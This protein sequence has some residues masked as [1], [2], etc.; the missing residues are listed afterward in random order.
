LTYPELKK[1]GKKDYDGDVFNASGSKV[2]R[3][4]DG[5]VKLFLK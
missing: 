5:I 1:I 3:N 4:D 2:G